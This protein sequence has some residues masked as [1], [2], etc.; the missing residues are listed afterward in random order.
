[1]SFTSKQKEIVARK[2]GYDGPMQGFDEYLKSSPALEMRYG[3]LSDKYMAK[4]G[5][6]KKY[7][8]GGDVAND[9]AL[10]NPAARIGS[11]GPSTGMSTGTMT[12]P[13]GVVYN[14]DGS[15]ATTKTKAANADI[16]NLYQS[17]LGRQADPEGAAFWEKQFGETV[18]PTEE[19]AFRKAAAGE[20][21]AKTTTGTTG[22]VTGGGA[23]TFTDKGVPVAGKAITV[24]PETIAITPQQLIADRQAGDVTKATATTAQD[25]ATVAAPVVAP[26]VK[27]EADTS[28]PAITEVLS[29]V[30]A[31]QGAVSKEA[32]VQAQ[33]QEPTTTAIQGIEAA[34]LAKAQKVQAPQERKLTTGELV[35]GP[36]VDQARAQAEAAA[37]EKAAAQ[38]TVTK[39]MTVKGQL[40]SLLTNFDAKNPPPWAAAS[41]RS[42]T[43]TLA[44]RGLGVSSLAGQALIQ[45]T[46]ESALPIASADAKAYQEV[47]AQNL[48]NRQQTAVLAAQQRAQFLGQEFDQAF[49]T[50]VTNA[51][52]VADI[53]NMNFTASQQ[54]ALENA[55]MAQTVDLAN[56][57]NSQGVVMAKA[58]QIASLETANLNNRQQAAVVNAQS[59]LAMDMKNLDNRQQTT[60]FKAQQMTQ[61]IL[62]DTGMQNA[63]KQFNAT[64]ENQ[65]NQF[66]T[67]MTTQVSQFNAAQK[68]AMN[69][70]NVDQTNSVAKFNAELV[71]QREQFNASQRLVIDQSNAQWRREVS[72]ANTAATNAANYLNAQNLQQT[73]LAEYNNAT[74]LYRDQVDNA[75]KSYES[76]QDRATT[77]AAATIAASATKTAASDKATADVWSAV[78][79]FAATLIK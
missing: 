27:Y 59:F 69:T 13:D 38:G 48:S 35:S 44:A 3:N 58:A 78:G 22:A 25:L 6:V 72:T 75:F 2:L 21:A 77:L 65:R 37:T 70:F 1:M 63:A 73:T 8:E 41:L 10:Y 36:A 23:V 16:S 19:A 64:S 17:V 56:L 62:S 11:I 33:T 14:A 30:K 32:Q 24:T 74:Q 79:S 71:S 20:L 29:G 60:L 5:M 52:R 40:D 18:D 49:Q 42:V 28:V 12:G 7:Q 76:D 46:L 31:E 4:G 45:A 68:N 61:A 50:K 34:Q 47:A 66:E 9:M 67:T 54:I 51:A 15:S 39:E 53:A 55:R 57:S 43:A 26:V